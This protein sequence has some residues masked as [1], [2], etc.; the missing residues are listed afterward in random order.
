DSNLQL[1]TNDQLGVAKQ[2]DLFAIQAVNTDQGVMTVTVLNGAAFS[3]GDIVFQ[4][5]KDQTLGPASAV[6]VAQNVLTLATPI[7]GLSNTDQLGHV[8]QKV[9]AGTTGQ[10]SLVS[11][12]TVKDHASVFRKGD[13][14]ARADGGASP[15]AR[16]DNVD[17]KKNIVTLSTA[18]PLNKN[19]V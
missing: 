11:R 1:S 7:N 19:D 10:Q 5:S 9:T 15:P 17:D 12:V 18:I 2:T 14:V 4:L 6:T 16:I 3:N 13:V 8:S